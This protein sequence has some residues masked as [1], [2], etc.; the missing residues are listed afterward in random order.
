MDN[1]PRVT[2]LFCVSCYPHISEYSPMPHLPRPT[3]KISIFFLERICVYDTSKKCQKTSQ[4]L[5]DAYML[6]T[7][8][9]QKCNLHF[10]LFAPLKHSICFISDV[11]FD[12]KCKEEPSFTMLWQHS[13]CLHIFGS[14][15]YSRT[16]RL[17]QILHVFTITNIAFAVNERFAVKNSVHKQERHFE[18]PKK[19]QNVT[20]SFPNVNSY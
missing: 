12:G 6:T 9:G 19:P 10:Q 2:Q 14:Q 11:P 7:L 18:E 1:A 5:M 20:Y 17:P 4:T 8:W 3:W 16:Y 13:S 15:R